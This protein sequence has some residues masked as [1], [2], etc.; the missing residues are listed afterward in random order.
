MCRARGENI[1]LSRIPA[2]LAVCW[3]P[4]VPPK[5][6]QSTKSARRNSEL[7]AGFI[8]LF[9]RYVQRSAIYKSPLPH[10]RP[11]LIL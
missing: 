10:V 11:H 7:S 5:C 4:I 6:N 3:L 8:A 1:P 2:S 9:L